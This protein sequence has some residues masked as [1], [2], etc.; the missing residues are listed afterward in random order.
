MS[1]KSGLMQGKR[2]VILG[3]ANNRSIAWGIAKACHDAGAEIA[4]TWQGDA[5]KKRV[6]PLAKELGGILLGHCDVTDAAT[7]DAVFEVLQ[8]E[9]GQDRLRR[10]RDRVLRQGP[11]RRPL[12]RDH[13]RQ[14]LQ[15]HADLAATRSPRS[16]SAPRS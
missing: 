11:A 2:G 15:D 8:G 4:L 13:G 1:E 6:E 9:M 12:S 16:R 3:V 7:I 14:F 5:L 10:A